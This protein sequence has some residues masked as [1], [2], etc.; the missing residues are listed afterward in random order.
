MT[1]KIATKISMILFPLISMLHCQKRVI[2]SECAEEELSL[3]V[4]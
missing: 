2:Y 3:P 4:L 1:K